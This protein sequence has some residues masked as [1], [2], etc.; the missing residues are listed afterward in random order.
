MPIE[1]TM[2]ALWSTISALTYAR[3]T[4]GVLNVCIPLSNRVQSPCRRAIN[5]RGF[6]GIPNKLKVI[7]N[8]IIS[9]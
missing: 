8:I 2:T 6:A 1:N 7:V 9:E 4:M 3:S 5:R